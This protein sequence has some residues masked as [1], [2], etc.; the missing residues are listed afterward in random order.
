MKNY[1]TLLIIIFGQ[2]L[3]AQKFNGFYIEPTV[4]SKIYFTKKSNLNPVQQSSYFTIQQKQFISLVGIDVGLNFG[5]SFKNNDKFQFGISQD[6]VEQ[7]FTSYGTSVITFTPSASYGQGRFSSYDGVSGTNF[8]LLYKRSVFNYK[9]KYLNTDRF[10]RMY[11]NFGLVY[12]FKP[13]NGIEN[14]TGTDSYGY[15]APDSSKVIISATTYVLPQPVKRSFKL[16]VGIDF[17]F[18]KNDKEWFSLNIS[19]ISN[20]SQQAFFSYTMVESKVIKPNGLT[21]QYVYYIKGTGN[22]IYF[23]LSKRL[24]PIKWHNERMAKKLEKLKS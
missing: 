17:T 14:L 7:G 22:G 6:Q 24:Y 2:A 3:L 20:R 11:F 23:T 8:T 15:T 1:I 21:Q 13:N 9:S 4:S 10:I 18:G 19:F 5:Y 12:F 16:N